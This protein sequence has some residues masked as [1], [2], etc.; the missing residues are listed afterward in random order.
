MT[1]GAHFQLDESQC[2]VI[3]TCIHLVPSLTHLNIFL[4]SHFSGTFIKFEIFGALVARLHLIFWVVAA[5]SSIRAG[6]DAFQTT[7]AA[8]Y[9][10]RL[11]LGILVIS[12]SAFEPAQNVHDEGVA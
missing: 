12:A 1:S 7:R 3:R 8:P 4:V 5:V 2:A 6:K 9:S 10:R 11:S